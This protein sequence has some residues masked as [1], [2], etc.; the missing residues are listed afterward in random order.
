MIKVLIPFT[1]PD[2]AERAVRRLLGE[3]EKSDCQV[4]LLAIV[5]PVAAANG[6]YSVAPALADEIARESALVWIARLGPLLAAASVPYHSTIV[7]GDHIKELEHA[8]HRRDVDRI[9]L[10]EA[11][12][13]S[14]GHERPV[15]VVA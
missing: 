7:V 1:E 8:L 3:P 6:R 11:A 5:A 12:H 2:G 13:R 10:P 15:T 9:L 4:E 14:I